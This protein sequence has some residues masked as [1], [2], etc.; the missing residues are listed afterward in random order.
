MS[1]YEVIKLVPR[2]NPNLKSH[3]V[4]LST[5]PRTSLARLSI[6]PYY[7]LVHVIHK[8]QSTHMYKLY[9][10][11]SRLN[12]NLHTETNQGESKTNYVARNLQFL[13]FAILHVLLPHEWVDSSLFSSFRAQL[14]TNSLIYMWKWRVTRNKHTTRRRGWCSHYASFGYSN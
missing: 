13:H 7:V 14:P 1:F 11:V 8:V 10:T 6:N 9:K 4:S 5:T 3:G 2:P 12:L